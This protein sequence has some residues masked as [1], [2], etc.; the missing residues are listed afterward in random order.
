MM[1]D[2]YGRTGSV[3][4][5]TPEW[6]RTFNGGADSA[7]PGLDFKFEVDYAADVPLPKGRVS[8]LG[9]AKDTIR[10]LNVLTNEWEQRQRKHIITVR[11][12]YHPY[13]GPDTSDE[14]Y[15]GLILETGLG[16]PPEQWMDFTLQTNFKDSAVNSINI[17]AKSMESD[18]TFLRIANQLRELF[19]C[20]IDLSLVSA[21]D[22]RRRCPKFT[23]EGTL[24]KI[25]AD[26]A[27]KA[28]VGHLLDMARSTPVL[29][30]YSKLD[31]NGKTIVPNTGISHSYDMDSGLIGIPRISGGL[32]LDFTTFLDP[33]VKFRDL[34]T[35]DSYSQGVTFTDFIVQSVHFSGHL[36]GNNWH[37]RIRAMAGPKSKIVRK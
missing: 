35:V 5:T 27:D 21:R 6:E 17:T 25:A 4:I 34:V 30:F 26:L 1:T 14:I 13:Q 33:S 29:R 15:S 37:T 11:A 19:K 32:F 20:T 22:L 18:C 8:I 23:S 9:L 36:R 31:A 7:Y 24:A 12:G 3:T 2:I 10:S 16:L 28:G